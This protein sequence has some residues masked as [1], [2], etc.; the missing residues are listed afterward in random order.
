[1]AF[2]PL[3]VA[4]TVAVLRV[5]Y[6]LGLICVDCGLLLA[7]QPAS[8]VR[9]NL[10]EAERLGFVCAGCRLTAAEAE[11]THAQ[12][13]AQAAVAREAAAALRRER[14]GSRPRPLKTTPLAPA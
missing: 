7:T 2:P 10:T 9:S 1:M 13:V 4:D 6:P 5:R 8:Y 12:R 11:S 3:S 14:D